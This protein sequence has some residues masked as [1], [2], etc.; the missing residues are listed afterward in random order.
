MIVDL[1]YIHLTPD[2]K[3]SMKVA[4]GSIHSDDCFVWH[5]AK[6]GKFLVKTAYHVMMCEQRD[7]KGGQTGEGSRV[8]SE[9]WQG[10]WKLNLPPKVTMFLWRACKNI[11]P[12]AVELLSLIALTKFDCLPVF[13]YLQDKSDSLVSFGA[14]LDECFVVKLMQSNSIGFCLK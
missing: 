10:I 3:N 12:H 14:I 5:H 11:L 13:C 8:E 9:E 4:M 1:R 7:D 2:K 6:D